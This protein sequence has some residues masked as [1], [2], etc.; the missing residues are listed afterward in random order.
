MKHY[1]GVR[2]LRQVGELQAA[3][4]T[5]RWTKPRSQCQ[6]LRI[7]WGGRRPAGSEGGARRSWR[8]HYYV[9]TMKLLSWLVAMFN[10]RFRSFSFSLY[11]QSISCLDIYTIREAKKMKFSIRFLHF[12]KRAGHQEINTSMSV[13]IL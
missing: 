13:F 5:L 8:P 11:M 1:I 3:E 2:F 4:A 7:S 6:V 9:L 12:G 10:G